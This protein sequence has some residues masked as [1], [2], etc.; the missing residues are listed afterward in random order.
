MIEDTI[1]PRSGLLEQT[2]EGGLAIRWRSLP[3][4]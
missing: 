4:A 3:A 1:L 2:A